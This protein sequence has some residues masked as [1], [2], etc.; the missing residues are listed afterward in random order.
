LLEDPDSD[1]SAWDARL[2]FKG[3]QHPPIYINIK[4]SSSKKRQKND[5]A[6]VK[7][8]K[9]FYDEN[10]NALLFFVVIKFNFDNTWIHFET[11][12]I[13]QYY[14][15]MKGYYIN[16]RNHHI[17]ATYDCGDEY[18]TLDEFITDFMSTAK[19]KGLI[20]N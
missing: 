14:P 16:P 2:H 19:E 11:E 12:P 3:E 18:R 6:S 5:I 13:V 10:P 9:Q 15:W 8:L 1:I 4:V 7:K 20:Y 17:Q